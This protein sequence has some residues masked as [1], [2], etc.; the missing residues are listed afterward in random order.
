M[1][2]VDIGE[3]SAYPFDGE[4]YYVPDQ[5]GS[6][7]TTLN[8][9]FN[10]GVTDHADGTNSPAG[11]TL[12]ETLGFPWAE[13]SLP[14]L[15]VLSEAVNPSTGDYALV[16]PSESLPG[17]TVSPLAVYGYPRFVNR[18]EVI[19]SLS[20]GG[21]TVESNKAAGGVTWRWS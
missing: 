9:Y 1:T 13:P 3:R 6:G 8:R 2:N 14:G 11:Y 12:E 17:Y 18:A 15:E 21:V 20:A 5:P 7:R 10:A 16:A 19:L 4:I